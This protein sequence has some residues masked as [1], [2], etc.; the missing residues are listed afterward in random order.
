M[1]VL[2]FMLKALAREI[3][4]SFIVKN[5]TCEVTAG[6]ARNVVV[7]HDDHITIIAHGLFHMSI[8]KV[9]NLRGN[10]QSSLF[11]ELVHI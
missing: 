1:C 10:I 7:Y 4:Q 6:H 11:K 8:N 2:C 3:E 5:V 9:H